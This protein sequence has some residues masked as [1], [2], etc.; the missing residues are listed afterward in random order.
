QEQK[1][2]GERADLIAAAQTRMAE[3][4]PYIPLFQIPQVA[5]TSDQISGVVLDAIQ[6]FRFW[7]LDKGA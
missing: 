2:P 1:N 3:E 6:V 7:L 5:V 4:V